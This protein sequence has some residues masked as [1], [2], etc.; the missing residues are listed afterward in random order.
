MIDKVVITMILCGTCGSDALQI[1]RVTGSIECLSCGDTNPFSIS[2]DKVLCDK[3]K[4]IDTI[5]DTY[6][7]RRKY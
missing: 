6:F 2:S 1:D 7:T 4:T 3:V 5:K